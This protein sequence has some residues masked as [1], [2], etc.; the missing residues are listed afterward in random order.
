VSGTRLDEALAVAGFD[1][2]AATSRA[3]LVRRTVAAFAAANGRPPAWAWFVPGRVEIFGKHTDYAGGSS[4]VAAVPRGFVIAAAPREDTLVT[5]T[6]AQ[7]QDR[8]V[9]DLAQPASSRRG[10]RNYVGVVLQRLAFNFPG[11]ALASDITIASDLPRAAGL[12]SSSAFVVGLAL[13]LVR[14]AALETRPEWRA[15]IHSRLELGGYLGA[16]ENGLGFG[17]LAS[18]D[19]VGTH[20]GSEDHTAILAS[21]ARHVAAFR[22]MPVRPIGDALMPAGWTFVMMTSG[23]HADKAG[24]VKGQYN[25]ASLATRALASLWTAHGGRPATLA[26]IL[27]RPGAGDALRA[28]LAAGADGFTA[29]DLEARLSHFEREQARVPAALEAFRVSDA[30]ALGTLSANSQ[31]DAE[32]LLGNQVP[33]TIALAATARGAGAFAASSFG[34]GFGGSVWALVDT[35]ASPVEAFAE[36]WRRRYLERYP[37]ANPVEWFAARPGP[38]ALE[39]PADA[40]SATGR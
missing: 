29:A 31:D 17:A 25:R 15:T 9:F 5:V 14:R 34:A 35:N 24:S 27:E 10:W 37:S 22:Y 4:L 7:W 12:S 33:E 26:E 16:V 19:G 40:D 18:T 23:V 32:H 13:A 20:G 1:G 8:A 38:A 21:R 28:S 6:D 36:L 39:L 2:E 11:A 30:A 3:A